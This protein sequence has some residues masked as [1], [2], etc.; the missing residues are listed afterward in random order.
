LGGYSYAIFLFH[1]LFAATSRV[2]L[3]R[4][5]VKDESLLVLGG[6][7]VGL[8]GPVVLSMVFS[9]FNFTS[10]LFL[11]ERAATKKPVV[12]VAPVVPVQNS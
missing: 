2:V 1:V 10:V 3:G 7:S 4:L 5:G 8:L 11:G 6:L 12:V 9:R